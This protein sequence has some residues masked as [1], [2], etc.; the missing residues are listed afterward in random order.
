VVRA[1]AGM[2]RAHEP[3]IHPASTSITGGH[4]HPMTA[5]GLAAERVG[6]VGAGVDAALGAAQELPV[7]ELDAGLVVGP[8]RVPAVGQCG[9]EQAGS[10]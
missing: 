2:M 6:Q 4:I 5:S 8:V 3:D 9:L 7:R 10:V 1:T